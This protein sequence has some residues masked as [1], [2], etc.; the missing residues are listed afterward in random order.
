MG[1][2]SPAPHCEQDKL[3]TITLLYLGNHLNTTG[4][5]LYQKLK[6]V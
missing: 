3:A 6:I 5:V 2:K 4:L 1:Q